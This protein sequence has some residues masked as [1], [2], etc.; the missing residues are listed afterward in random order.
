MSNK[1]FRVMKTLYL[2]KDYDPL[3]NLQPSNKEND[4]LPKE[5]VFIIIQTLV[6]YILKVILVF[7][8]RA[9]Y[10]VLLPVP[11]IVFR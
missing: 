1:V 9:S 4:I 8:T 5:P 2:M 6:L 11:Y 3:K 7:S 10:C